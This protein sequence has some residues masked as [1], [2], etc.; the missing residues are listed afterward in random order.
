MSIQQNGKETS[1][2][3]TE[4]CHRLADIN[5]EIYELQIRIEDIES[6]LKWDDESRKEWYLERKEELCVRLEECEAK[7]DVF[8]NEYS[9]ILYS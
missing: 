9:D 3:K 1:M 6:R 2:D 8:I 7:H 4:A 5:E